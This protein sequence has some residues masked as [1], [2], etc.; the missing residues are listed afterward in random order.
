MPKTRHLL[1][2][3]SKSNAQILFKL[4]QNVGE[5]VTIVTIDL[6]LQV[7]PPPMMVYS[8]LKLSIFCIN[9]KN[10]VKIT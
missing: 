9:F 5:E 4:S 10:R 6:N 3:Y 2:V 8:N 7:V 1:T